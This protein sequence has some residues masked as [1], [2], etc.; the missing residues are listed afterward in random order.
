LEVLRGLQRLIAAGE[1]PRPRRTIHFIWSGEI[2]GTYAFFKNHPG[3]TD[4]LSININM[5]MVGEGLRKN[6]GVFR[7]SQCPEHL[8]S[9]LDGLT[10]SIMEYVWRTNDIIFMAEGPRG[11]PGGQY[12]PIPMV[13]KNGSVDAFRYSILPT[14]GGSDQICFHN[15]SVAVPSIMLIIW[16]DQW[17]HADTD[18]PDKADPTQLKRAAFVGGASAWAAACCTDEVVGPLAEVTS[19]YGYLRVAAREIPRAMARLDAADA[20]HLAGETVQSLRLIA[21]GTGREIEAL[22]SIEEISSGSAAASGA[23]GARLRQWDLY[24]RALRSQVLEYGKCRAAQLNVQPPAEPAAD[25]MQQKY[26]KIVP[27][28]APSVKGQQFEVSRH[29]SYQQHL[30]KHPDAVKSL[31]IT[32]RQAMTALNYVN[33]RRSVAEICTCVAAELDEDVPRQAVAGYLELLRSV[34]WLV[35]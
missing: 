15:P 23:V 9:Y 11:R 30:K 3:F 2:S 12:F 8:P 34:G 19:D 20:A 7:M 14:V 26:E 4:R 21:C 5:D 24:R 32:P 27:A 18:T 6:N 17:Y 10:R 29:E 31:G 28:I 35:F 13:E 1:L 22:R 25:E 16:P 33:G